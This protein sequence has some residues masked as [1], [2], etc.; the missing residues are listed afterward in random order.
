M[1]E[2]IDLERKHDLSAMG[3][4]AEAFVPRDEIGNFCAVE[5]RNQNGT[6]IKFDILKIGRASC[7]ERV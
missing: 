7:R 4:I 1:S 5:E 2:I 3:I 6:R